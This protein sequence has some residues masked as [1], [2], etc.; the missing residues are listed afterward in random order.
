MEELCERMRYRP[1]RFVLEFDE[2][3]DGERLAG[4]KHRTFQPVDALWLTKSLSAAL[5]RHETV[6][7]LFARHLPASAPDV[8]PAIQG[9]SETL[10]TILP[11]TPPRLRKHLA[12]PDAGSAC[13]RLAMYLRWMVPPRPGRL[14][15]LD[16][17]PPSP[18]R[19]PLGR[20]CR[21]SGTG[22]RVAPS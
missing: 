1:Y 17:R 13:K 7:A 22:A 21:T 6:E 8:R 18:A 3:R 5:R 19:A 11:Q 4:F 2:A 10:L 20:P 12:R 14:R 15:P 9:F 16:G